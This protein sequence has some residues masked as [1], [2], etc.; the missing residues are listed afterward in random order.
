MKLVIIYLFQALSAETTLEKQLRRFTQL[1]HEA[2]ERAK[3]SIEAQRD[4]T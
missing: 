4:M 1:R 2:V 3:A